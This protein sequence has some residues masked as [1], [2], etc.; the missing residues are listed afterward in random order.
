MP[1]SILSKRNHEISGA[2]ITR[3]LVCFRG[4]QK[5]AIH[6]TSQMCKLLKENFLSF[7]V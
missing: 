2:A 4:I 6:S 7:N 1:N 5:Y 3:F